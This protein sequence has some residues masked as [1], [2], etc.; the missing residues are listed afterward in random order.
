MEHVWLNLPSTIVS[1]L[2]ARTNLQS[3]LRG[4]IVNIF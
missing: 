1:Q 4:A 3:I 2:A